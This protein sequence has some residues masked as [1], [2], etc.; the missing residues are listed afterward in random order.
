[1][2]QTLIEGSLLQ[3]G[4]YKVESVLGQ[5]GFGITYKALFTKLNRVV[6]IKE[7]F[8]KDCH[9]RLAN[10]SVAVISQENMSEVSSCQEKF[11]RE[12][13]LI[14]QMDSSQHIVHIYDVF[15][16][17]QT[18]Y[19]VMEYIKSDTLKKLI[20]NEGPLTELRALQIVSN[21]S[22]GLR[23]LHE[24]H[25]MHLDVKPAN[26]MLRSNEKDEPDVV[27]IDFGISKHYDDNGLQTESIPVAISKGFA[28]LEQYQDGGLKQFSPTADIY[29]LCALL[30]YLCTAQCPPE[31]T[32]LATHA[33]QKPQAMSLG[34]WQ[35]VCKGMNTKPEMRYQSVPALQADL[36]R[37]LSLQ[38]N[39]QKETNGSVDTQQSNN[40]DTLPIKQHHKKSIW[41]WGSLIL[42]VAAIILAFLMLGHCNKNKSHSSVIDS[43]ST[44]TM[45]PKLHVISKD[46]IDQF[47]NFVKDNNGEILK[48]YG[49]VDGSGK[50][51]VDCWW[52]TA[53]YFKQGTALV[54]DYQNQLTYIDATGHPITSIRGTAANV[55]SG[56]LG[57]IMDSQNG[58]YGAIDSLGNQRIDFKWNYLVFNDAEEEIGSMRDSNGKY[59]L[60]DTCGNVILPCQW[61][62]IRPLGNRIA[63]VRNDSSFFLIHADSTGSVIRSLPNYRDVSTF[64]EGLSI[65]TDNDNKKGFI[66]ITGQIVSDC[67]WVEAGIFSCGL[68]KVKNDS[69]LWG[70]IDR[71]GNKAIDF[72]FSDAGTFS[73]GL[74]WAKL[75]GGKYG[76]IGTS[77]EFIIAPQWNSIKGFHQGLAAV[78]GPNNMW[79]YINKQGEL[80]IP[81]I[82]EKVEDFDTDGLAWVFNGTTWLL[83]D[84][85][86]DTPFI[87]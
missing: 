12:A 38:E 23:H 73:E 72:I 26:V 20:E 15:E 50:L 40:S 4:R 45:P 14:A 24:H 85:H 68:A 71:Q 74:A 33:L 57:C 10:G 65:I 70:Y 21:V 78:K 29:S 35:I 18:V 79:G 31:A 87:R 43:D 5:G 25:I 19:Y 58:K 76:F 34:V 48:N 42:I 56:G 2:Q 80:V 39:R 67:Q 69:L 52:K 75:K 11:K 36:L 6:A 37:E 64:T 63:F 41:R 47:G 84:S 7:L 86:G 16:E 60:I 22:D 49:Y 1:M 51:V 3:G 44:E 46:S 30:Y 77:G 9:Q 83:I 82:W 8:I 81:Y 55:F 66:S 28:P 17:N 61:D 54:K 53:W 27:L 32:H 62:W 59:G 13:L